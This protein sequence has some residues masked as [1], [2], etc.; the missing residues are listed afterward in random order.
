MVD[1]NLAHLL[2]IAD[3]LLHLFGPTN[4]FQHRNR[5]V[6]LPLTHE[7]ARRLRHYQHTNPQQRAG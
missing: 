3:L 7:E 2:D 1:A 6:Y 5:F 4:R